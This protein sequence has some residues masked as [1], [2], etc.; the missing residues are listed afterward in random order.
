MLIDCVWIFAY[1]IYFPTDAENK[2]EI[3]NHMQENKHEK[4]NTHNINNNGSEANENFNNNKNRIENIEDKQ[5]SI[6]F[7]EYTTT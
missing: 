2:S 1:K 3:P 7:D 5:K 6:C 4:E